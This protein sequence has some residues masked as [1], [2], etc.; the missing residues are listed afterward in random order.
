LATRI[1]RIIRLQ[2]L[3]HLLPSESSNVQ[4]KQKLRML[5]HI[6]VHL[7]LFIRLILALFKLIFLVDFFSVLVIDEIVVI[8]EHEIIFITILFIKF[9]LFLRA[10]LLPDMMSPCLRQSRN[11]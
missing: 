8:F 7:L 3:L 1:L 10:Q 6:I 4:S 5:L 2:A 11:S 9:F